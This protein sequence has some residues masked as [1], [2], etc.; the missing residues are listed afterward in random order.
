MLDSGPVHTETAGLGERLHRRWQVIQTFFKRDI[1]LH[2]PE[3]RIRRFGYHVLRM[4]VLTVEG[5]VR[6]DVFLLAAALTYQVIFALVPLLAVV[7]S[8][9]KGFGGLSGVSGKA[10]DYL[11]RYIT[12]EV[13]DKLVT[14]IDSF[15]G[16]INAAA[17]G[18][19]GFLALIYTALSLMQTVEKT[20]NKIWGIKSPRPFLRRLMVY[21]TMLTVS[22]ILLVASVAMTTFVQSNGLYGWLTKNVPFFGSATL[23]LTPFVFAWILFTGIYVFMPNTRVQIRSAFIGA[24]VAGTS[25]ELMKSLYVW[26]NAKVVTAYTFYGSLGSIPIFLLWIYLSW[27]IVLFG[28]EVAFAAQHVETYKREIDVVK[29]S[30]ADRERLSLVAAILAVKPFEAGEPPPTAD[31]IASAMNAPVRVIHDILYE[32]AAKGILR[33]VGLGGNKDPGYLPARNP[34]QLTARDV[35]RAVRSYGDDYKL[36]EGHGASAVYRLIDDAEAHATEALSR[37]TLKDLASRNGSPAAPILP[38]PAQPG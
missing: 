19:V 34:E 37:V 23:T 27:I 20:F 2:K 18:V 15:I 33:E 10:K 24:L 25:W 36:P 12:P 8:M 21:W 38:D 22:P 32:L 1:W 11:L 3:S 6:S 28:A 26:Y 13:G 9:F 30:H 7:L 29:V 17:I 14:T 4:G 31:A 5:A 35:L 16:N